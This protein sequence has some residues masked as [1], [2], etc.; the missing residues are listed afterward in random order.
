MNLQSG[1]IICSTREAKKD[2]EQ[3]LDEA[4]DL[5]QNMKLCLLCK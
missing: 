4:K 2:L 5:E 1:E 3:M